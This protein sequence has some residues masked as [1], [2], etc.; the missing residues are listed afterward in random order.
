MKFTIHVLKD[1]QAGFK[2]V[3]YIER[4]LWIDKILVFG[5]LW[6]VLTSV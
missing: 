3:R 5:I 1:P 6:I 4:Y 2:Q